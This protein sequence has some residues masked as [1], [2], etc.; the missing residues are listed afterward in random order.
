MEHQAEYPWSFFFRLRDDQHI[1]FARD[2]YAGAPKNAFDEAHLTRLM[3][4]ISKEVDNISNTR[5]S[6]TREKRDALVANARKQVA[7]LYGLIV[8]AVNNGET[9]AEAMLANYNSH[10][11]NG[12]KITDR[13]FM[14]VLKAF[15]GDWKPMESES[16]EQLILE[17]KNSLSSYDDYCIE[18]EKEELTIKNFPRQD[19]LRAQTDV[20]LRTLVRRK[21]VEFREL[22]YDIPIEEGYKKAIDAALFWFEGWMQRVKI[23]KKN[24]ASQTPEP[25]PNV[26]EDEIVKPIE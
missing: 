11:K 23:A 18:V 4:Y 2:F 20:W 10:F 8:V 12:R 9:E 5:K 16:P 19:D 21:Q 14:A 24:T 1:S 25:E 15:V 17:L 13:G 3:E 7:S 22:S 26:A 6:V